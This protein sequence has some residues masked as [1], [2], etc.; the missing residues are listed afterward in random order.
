MRVKK[1]PESIKE[2]ARLIDEKLA[3]ITVLR[4][5]RRFRRVPG[6]HDDRDRPRPF[7]AHARTS[8]T[9][10]SGT[11]YS[12]QAPRHPEL[13]L[14][15][16]HR[17]RRGRDR[18]ARASGSRSW[19]TRKTVKQIKPLPNLF[20]KI[21]TGNSLLGVEKTLFNEELF[22]QLEELKPR[23]FDEPDKDKKDRYKQ[24]IE[25]TIH[26]LTK[27]KQAFDFEIYFSEVFHGKGGFDVL[28]A[29]P[30]YVSHDRISEDK[31]GL[32]NTFNVYDSF[33]DIYCYFIERGIN[34]LKQCGVLTFITSNSYI[35]A[36]YGSKLSQIPQQSFLHCPTT[37]H[38]TVTSF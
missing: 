30:P 11:P 10:T 2:H 15:R 22:E 3:D 4:S 20:Y 24:Q 38:R 18:Q 14:R 23:Y 33:A 21:V 1:C 7:R 32:R 36:D 35:K 25:A 31:N 17:P 12:L 27:G 29:N 6:R 28:I 26:E 5:R 8:T 19:W 9:F 16:G 13:P 37:Q 34:I